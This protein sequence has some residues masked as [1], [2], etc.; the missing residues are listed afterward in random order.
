MSKLKWSRAIAV[1]LMLAV[2]FGSSP[3]ALPAVA[4]VEPPREFKAIILDSIVDVS[5]LSPNG[6]Q[7]AVYWGESCQETNGYW[8]D[9]QS[10]YMGTSSCTHQSGGISE[11]FTRDLGYIPS[12]TDR[13]LVQFAFK[14][15]PWGNPGSFNTKVELLR[16]NNSVVGVSQEFVNSGS[17]RNSWQMVQFYLDQWVIDAFRGQNMKLEIRSRLTNSGHVIR[18][19]EI[20][21][22]V[23]WPDAPTATPLPTNTPWPTNTPTPTRTAVSTATPTPTRTAVPTATPTR[24][25]T[26]TP[27][28]RPTATATPT[29]DIPETGLLTPPSSNTFGDNVDRV[30]G[31]A[32]LPTTGGTGSVRQLEG[33]E[34]VYSGE[35][36]LYINPACID[37]NHQDIVP[38]EFCDKKRML[39][40]KEISSATNG[41]AVEY[42]C[43]NNPIGSGFYNGPVM[44]GTTQTGVGGGS[45]YG[46]GGVALALGSWALTRP[47]MVEVVW[48]PAGQL[49]ADQGKMLAASFDEAQLYLYSLLP[50]PAAPPG[51]GYPPPVRTTQ[52]TFLGNVSTT[53]RF[54][55]T[56]TG[57]ALWDTQGWVFDGAIWNE[58]TVAIWQTPVIL[59]DGTAEL[60]S[61]TFMQVPNGGSPTT[62]WDGIVSVS[63]EDWD[64]GT[65]P[66][67]APALG[68]GT[69]STSGN[70]D[71]HAQKISQWNRA[72]RWIKFRTD[73]GKRPNWDWCGRR[74]SD[75][76]CACVN[77]SLFV[78]RALMFAHGV[79]QQIS[80]GILVLMNPANPTAWGD[81]F[82]RDPAA[83][84]WD[85]MRMPENWSSS[86]W[87]T[88]SPG[89]N[90]CDP[91]LGIGLPAAA[92]DTEDF[93]PLLE[94]PPV[95]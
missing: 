7:W 70:P 52:S 66:T 23:F 85:R 94:F 50:R 81:V 11:V 63:L 48:A 55:R 10:P 67:G 24:T 90:R 89:D 65:L 4:Q 59:P 31:V 14:L 78:K 18:L 49:I 19:D 83:P 35:P 91:S 95:E 69:H 62:L 25:P 76:V 9:G 84:K 16:S 87:E 92:L 73:Q 80:Q 88:L 1:V 93:T 29:P 37:V 68:T 82:P 64:P 72:W 26:R 45:G 30:C 39:V 32:Y 8:S 42:R 47:E 20:G 86:D 53:Y 33:R 60:K 17:P 5:N 2:V 43:E 61:W 44:M 13:V 71:E 54:Y 46:W 3:T 12:N 15:E 36:S 28:P 34:P 22:Y 27:T 6:G 74:Y 41:W 38:P 21:A 75:G 51:I 57:P 79:Q 56:E 40:I 58:W 77:Y